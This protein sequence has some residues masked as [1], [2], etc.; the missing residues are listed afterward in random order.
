MGV[1]FEISG[2]D[3]KIDALADAA[4]AFATEQALSDCSIY[5]PYR[6]GYLRSSGAATMDKSTGTIT[7]QT[8]YARR[9]YYGE[10]PLKGRNPN[11]SLRWAEVAK[12]N[13]IQDWIRAAEEGMRGV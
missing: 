4:C 13:H 8:P 6:N 11:A 1:R 7:W 2:L 12:Q 3:A 10:P 5:V 9:R